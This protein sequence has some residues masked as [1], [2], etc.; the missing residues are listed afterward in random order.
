[1]TLR[2]YRN[3]ETQSNVTK[4]LGCFWYNANC[5]CW[6]IEQKFAPDFKYLNFHYW[7]AK[8]C[9]IVWHSFDFRLK[10]NLFGE[11]LI[12]WKKSQLY[13]TQLKWNSKATATTTSKLLLLSK[14]LKIFTVHSKM[15]T[16]NTVS[17]SDFQGSW[18]TLSR[19]K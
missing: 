2:G 11:S 3:I 4:L 16:S 8:F 6:R 10:I 18:V 9:S 5:E 15:T 12:I 14:H 1:M 13:Y 7:G 19:W 17:V